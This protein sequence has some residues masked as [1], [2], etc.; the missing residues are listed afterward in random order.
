MADALAVLDALGLEKAWA[1]GHS[2]GGHLALHLAVAHPDRL[3]GVVCIGTLG[4]SSEIFPDF[5]AA[6]ERDL[7]DD[8]RA[9]VE[10]IRER[11]TDGTVTEEELLE[12]MA[13]VW[14]AYFADPATAPPFFVTAR[15]VEATL[16]TNRSIS[17][18]FERKTLRR[19]LPQFDLPALFVHGV[20]DPLPA[21]ASINTAKLLPQSRV[22]RITRCGHFPWLEQPGTLE[23]MVR[24]LFAQL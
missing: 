14:P 18:H 20:D 24:G 2:W 5:R 12:D 4:A 16:E 6:L 3:H 8:Q 19:G 10:E 11:K 23:R 13:L 7:S 9:R 1:V 22:A 21:R 17:E 15:G